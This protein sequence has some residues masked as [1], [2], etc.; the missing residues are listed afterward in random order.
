MG[1]KENQNVWLDLNENNVIEFSSCLS[2]D[3]IE[4]Q[5]LVISL[6]ETSNDATEDLQYDTYL[7]NINQEIS[8]T[9]RPNRY[10]PCENENYCNNKDQSQLRKSGKEVINKISKNVKKTVKSVA[11]NSQNMSLESV[12]K[13]VTSI[14]SSMKKMAELS[15]IKNEPLSDK[16][17]E[18]LFHLSDDLFASYL[19]NDSL[20][21]SL[22]SNLWEVS[23]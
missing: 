22:L 3:I 14:W 9:I 6:P 16:A 11:E 12:Q 4:I 7:D 19:E 15:L 17:E 10:P 2:M 18:N 1:L 23:Y 8:Q 21:V 20:H 13:G 5:A